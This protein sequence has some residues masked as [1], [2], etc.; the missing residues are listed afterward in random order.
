M[1]IM[2][3]I[4]ALIVLV[5]KMELIIVLNYLVVDLKGSDARPC[6]TIVYLRGQ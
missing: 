6:Q 5:V 2:R 3:A 1:R 4:N